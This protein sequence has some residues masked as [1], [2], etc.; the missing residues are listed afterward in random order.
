M[1]ETGQDRIVSERCVSARQAKRLLRRTP[2]SIP[3]HRHRGVDGKGVLLSGPGNA[4]FDRD[5]IAWTPET[6]AAADRVESG[7]PFDTAAQG[8]NQ[9][10]RRPDDVTQT[11]AAE[12][13]VWDGIM[14]P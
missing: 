3:V 7:H 14:G 4:G 2:F 10:M 5:R 13:L 9:P 11:T 12:V 8:E 1:C 6:H